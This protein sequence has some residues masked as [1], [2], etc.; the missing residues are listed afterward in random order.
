[1]KHARHSIPAGKKEKKIVFCVFLN[2]LITAAE[3][4]GGVMSGSVSLLSD[5]LH[6]FSDTVSL[7]VSLIAIKLSERQ[8]TESHTFGYKRAEILAALFNASVL[9]IV[10]FFL[11]KEAGSRLFTPVFINSRLMIS[12]ALVGLGANLVAVLLLRKDACGDMN[13]KSAYLHLFAD[14]LSSAGVI[15]GGILI[16]LF[17]IY[18]I[19]S[20]LTVLIGLYVLKEGYLLVCDSLRMLMQGTP[21]GLD[22]RGIQRDVELLGGVKDIHHVHVWEIRA[23]DI[24]FEA[25]INL[26]LDMKISESCEL[27][28]RIEKLLR[29]KYQVTHV[30][31]QFEYDCCQGVP[32]IK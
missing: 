10:S 15:A 17:K 28:A 23:G 2:F 8:R 20:V 18:W 30:T 3:I 22:I 7:V 25:H 31:I 13:V 9:V 16:F 6:N 19:D 1:M 11:F 29:E 4:A 21:E 12:V 27:K 14:A 5:A 24:H 32:L 26:S